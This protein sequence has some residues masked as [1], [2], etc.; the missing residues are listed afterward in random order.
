MRTLHVK[1]GM[2]GLLALGACGKR[3]LVTPQQAATSAPSIQTVAAKW[4]YPGAAI[5]SGGATASLYHM[6]STTDQTYEE[7]WLHYA[8][9][10]GYQP[11][12]D[13]NA[14]ALDTECG[15]TPY[16]CSAHAMET[17]NAPGFRSISFALSGNG[18]AVVANISRAD[19]EDRTHIQLTIFKN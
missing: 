16:P 3:D 13:P 17:R 12:F 4:Q 7:V 19:S 10:A 1:L 5:A 9:L 14:R 6:A 15:D 2:A 11:K 18:V 8:K